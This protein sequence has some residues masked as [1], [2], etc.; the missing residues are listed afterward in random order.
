MIKAQTHLTFHANSGC[1]RRHQ[2]YR[3]HVGQGLS[4]LVQTRDI[5]LH[6]ASTQARSEMSEAQLIVSEAIL[7]CSMTLMQAIKGMGMCHFDFLRSNLASACSTDRARHACPARDCAHRE[8]TGLPAC[9]SSLTVPCHPLF[10]HSS[11]R[12]LSSTSVTLAGWMVLCLQPRLLA[13]VLAPSCTSLPCSVS[14]HRPSL[15]PITQRD[16]GLGGAWAGQV[17]AADGLRT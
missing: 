2:P 9:V 7:G 10:V 6:F 12:R 11:A 4:A 14:R 3:V 8:R 1:R 13:L 16:C 15:S 5:P 17:R